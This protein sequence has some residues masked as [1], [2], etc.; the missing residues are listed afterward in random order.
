[1]KIKKSYPPHCSGDT[2]CQL[3]PS[4]LKAQAR[5]GGIKQFSKKP[6][7]QSSW[8]LWHFSP[9]NMHFIVQLNPET[10]C[11]DPSIVLLDQRLIGFF[12]RFQ[13]KIFI[14]KASCRCRR[15]RYEVMGAW[16]LA[17]AGWWFTIRGEPLDG[18]LRLQLQDQAHH[19]FFRIVPYSLVLDGGAKVT[20]SKTRHAS[21]RSRFSLNGY[22]YRRLPKV[23]SG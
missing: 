1:M 8:D 23:T 18:Y 22:G 6:S 10:S 13:W 7:M 3:S 11:L 2:V 14:C 9:L 20:S 5:A 4:A 12:L 15:G 16:S 19:V 17:A 21:L